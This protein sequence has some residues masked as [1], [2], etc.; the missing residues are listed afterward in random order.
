MAIGV[1]ALAALYLAS[2]GSLN[3]RRP[4]VQDRPASGGQKIAFLAGC[5]TVLVALGPPLEDWSELLPSGHM[6]QHVLL[7]MLVPPLLLLR[8][9]AWLLR[10]LLRWKLVAKLGYALTR[11]PVLFALAGSV[12][13]A[14]DLAHSGDAAGES[15]H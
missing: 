14:A 11:A 10:P 8:T 2:V 4:G 5:A 7:T 6:V 13:L 12:G 3:R 9:P 15:V 1:F